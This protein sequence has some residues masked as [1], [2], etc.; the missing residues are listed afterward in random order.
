MT[1][2]GILFG[3]R[4]AEHEVSLQSARNLV[5][6]LDRERYKPVLV[7]IDKEGRWLHYPDEQRFLE[8]SDD[9]ERIRLAECG[10]PVTLLPW[11][12]AGRLVPLQAGVGRSRPSGSVAGAGDGSMRN[13]ETDNDEAAGQGT[14][15]PADQD[16]GNGPRTA[17][18]F[19]DD[20]ISPTA[21]APQVDVIF[22]VL[23]GPL[24]ED[25][26][27]Q[28]LFRLAEMAFVGS[29]VLG[30]SAGMDKDLQKRLLGQAGIR[31]A[32]WTLLRSPEEADF[33]AL[34]REFGLPLFVKPANMGS[35]VGVHKVFEEE[36]LHRAV[37]DALRFDL[38]VLVEKAIPGREIE[39]SVL[40]NEDARA[41]LPGE[42][43]PKNG[44]YS[45]DAKYVDSEGAELIVPARISRPELVK[46][47]QDW[48]VRAFQALCCRGLARADFFL[49]DDN[50]LY[51]NEINTMP[52]FTRISMY[53]KLWDATG[54]PY[55]ELI[56]C[57]IQLALD[58]HHR[59]SQLATSYF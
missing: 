17:Q 47:I 23:H 6:A 9:P 2:V 13:T 40:G 32:P 20:G 5:A 33:K 51:L 39:C 38:K 54:I 58:H 3:G 1:R 49:S 22:P 11:N 41:S 14:Q 28:G 45:Y 30:S 8:N 21:D 29:G 46:Q 35:S 4:S 16:G 27:I 10:R 57:L 24:G 55:P 42:I 59:R 53:P 7:G 44:F 25:G 19:R 37:R 15:G 50:E 43:V 48:S 26:T 36:G 56:H 12:N 34:S 31:V 18:G 52:G